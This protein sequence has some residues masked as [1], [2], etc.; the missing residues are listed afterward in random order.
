MKRATRVATLTNDDI[1][2]LTQPRAAFMNDQ[3][4]LSAAAAKGRV[5]DSRVFIFADDDNR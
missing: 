2:S 4:R 5:V 3:G 1:D